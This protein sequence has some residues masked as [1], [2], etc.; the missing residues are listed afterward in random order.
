[1]PQNIDASI[2]VRAI[3]R[4]IKSRHSLSGTRIV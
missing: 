2:P 4:K 3:D 1:M